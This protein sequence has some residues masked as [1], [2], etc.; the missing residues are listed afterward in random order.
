MTL[1]V[2]A[3]R[4]VWRQ[5]RR[6][7]LT[8]VTIALGLA[9]LLVSIGLGDG[10]HYQ[11][12]E[13]AVSMG[14]GHVVIQERGYQESGDAGKLLS[15]EDQHRAVKWIDDVRTRFRVRDVVER[16]FASGLASS[17]EDAAGVLIMGIEPGDANSISA[18]ADKLVAGSFPEGR[19]SERAVLGQGVARKLG[20]RVGEKFVITAQSVK[21]SQIQSTLVRAGGVMHTGLEDLDEGAVLLPIETLQRFLNM[22]HGVHQIAVILEQSRPSQRLADLGKKRLPGLEVLSWSEALPELRDF[23]VLDDA[24]NYMFNLVIFILVAFLVMNT[25]QMSVL[26]RNREFALLDA[27]G[28]PPGKRFAM[29]IVEGLLVAALASGAGLGLGLAAHRFLS[30]HGLPMDLFYSGEISAAGVAFDPV[31]YSDLSIN[32]VAGS[33]AVVFVVTLVLALFPARRAARAGD[34]HL[35]G[36]L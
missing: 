36:R 12:I 27:L 4:N 19:D 17:A 25:L 1:I 23:I 31:I 7:I 14:S 30:V 11:M 33:T 18:F 28:M 3:W 24:G 20:L 26:E 6:T 13:S 15:P 32:R 5:P 35:L 22:D 34:P 8:V 10:G 16:V 2:I 9:L 29:I 21:G